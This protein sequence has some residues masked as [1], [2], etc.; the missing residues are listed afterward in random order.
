MSYV[1]ASLAPGETLVVK[2]R[3][4]WVLWLRAV[5]VLLVFGWVGIGI[6]WFIRDAFFLMSTEMA[7]TS[8]RLIYKTG[9][10]H[11]STSELIL[12]SIEAVKIEQGFWGRL[13]GFGRL[14]VHGTGADVWKTPLIDRPLRFRRAIAEAR[15]AA[16][17]GAG[18][19]S[20]GEF[21][22]RTT[23]S[24]PRQKRTTSARR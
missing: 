9:L 15:P 17:S 11:R 4:H 13:F 21:P 16:M 24:L 8:R 22:Q 23:I 3:L 5:L 18:S 7:L 19:G 14:S 1:A 12:T 10:L 6:Y 20:G 2:A